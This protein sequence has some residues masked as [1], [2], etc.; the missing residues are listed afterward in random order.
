M[1]PSAQTDPSWRSP[2]PGPIPPGGRPDLPVLFAPLLSCGFRQGEQ[3]LEP[4]PPARHF[5]FATVE[6]RFPYIRPLSPRVTAESSLVHTLPKTD[7]GQYQPDFGR[8][9]LPPSRNVWRIHVAKF[10]RG[11]QIVGQTDDGK[12]GGLP[13]EHRLV[14]LEKDHVDLNGPIASQRAE[15][16]DSG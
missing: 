5:P 13:K 10:E 3:G 7:L 15:L 14:D 12:C 16:P 9:H 6:S 4:P 8:V 11:R 2:W 1:E